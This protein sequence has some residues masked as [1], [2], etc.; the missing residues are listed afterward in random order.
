[1]LQRFSI[2]LAL[3]DILG[4]TRSGRDD[5][6]DSMMEPPSA[7]KPHALTLFH[8]NAPN[9]VAELREHPEL[10][11]EDRLTACVP[12]WELPALPASWLPILDAMDIILAPSRFVEE[13]VR[14][15]LPNSVCIHYR[16]TVFVPDNVHENRSR[17]GIPDSAFAF[18]SSFDI[19]SD[20][21][22]K[23]PE[24]VIDAFRMA[25]PGEH[26]VRLVLK[27]NSSQETRELFAD[28]L[29][30]LIESAAADPRIVLI[31]RMLDYGDVL[32]LYASSDVLVSL[33]RSEGLGLS[34]MEAMALGKPV[35]TTAWSGNMD[36]STPENSCLVGYDLVSVVST[37]PAYASAVI[38]AGQRWAEP[39]V[40][41]AAQHMRQLFYDRDLTARLGAQAREDLRA[42]RE[43]YEGGE[44]VTALREAIAPTS[45]VWR[46]H[47]R[48]R[49]KLMRIVRGPRHLSLRRITGAVLRRCPLRRVGGRVLRDLGLRKPAE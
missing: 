27:I 20:L 9:L 19:T 35:I 26:D 48:K 5:T 22:R 16:Q 13:A 45:P 47:K 49:A 23:N 7:A 37:V 32:S 31:D 3:T 30:T 14:T 29:R 28:R 15:A 46:R 38:G 24:A 41:E 2:P 10:S 39:R 44:M 6:Y 21:A 4:D 1:M 34:L 40:A 33:H 25:F 12:F 8:M 42:I 36:F 17:W 43:A 18:V 11:R